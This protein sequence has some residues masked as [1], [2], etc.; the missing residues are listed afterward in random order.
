LV[1]KF[2]TDTYLISLH[3]SSKIFGDYILHTGIHLLYITRYG[4]MEDIMIHFLINKG[5]IIVMA[6]NIIAIIA[7]IVAQVELRRAFRE[8]D[9]FSASRASRKTDSLASIKDRANL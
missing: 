8:I 3:L 7:M 9:K 2:K 5:T 4:E 1:K 6:L